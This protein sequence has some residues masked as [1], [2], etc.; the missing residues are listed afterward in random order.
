MRT[1]T[2]NDWTWFRVRAVALRDPDGQGIVERVG[3]LID[4]DEEKARQERR[5]LLLVDMRH[6]LKNFM[7]VIQAIA[8][9]S[10]PKNDPGVAA[11]AEKFLARIRALEAAGDLVMK[12]NASDVDLAEM[13]PAAIAPFAGTFGERIQIAGPSLMLK[14]HT[15]GGIALALNELATNA[16][17]YGALS[18]D[19]GRVSIRWWSDPSDDGDRV[20]LDW[21]E[22]GGPLVQPPTR[23]GFGTRIIRS[24]VRNEREQTVILSYAP[25]G[26]FC[27][28]T[29]VRAKALVDAGAAGE[30]V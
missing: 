27:R 21:R 22:G 26:L 17:K 20:T 9:S 4:I 12:A 3:A 30:R 24:A 29:F 23:E 5:E 18:L 6:R 15:V 1:Q 7:A 13:A 14:E 11:F 16:V 10:M 25:E 8:M 19:G 28:M 2:K